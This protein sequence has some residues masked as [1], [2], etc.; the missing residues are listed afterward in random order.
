M[1]PVNKIKYNKHV[2]R[3]NHDLVAAMYAMY[4]T[5]KSCDA[6]AV[7]YRRSRQAIY[8]MFKT[9]G[10]KLRERK[11]LP[12]IMF[13]GLKFTINRGLYRMTTTRGKGALLHTYIYEKHH[14]P[15]PAGH[16]I[17]HENGDVLDNRIEN[18]KLYSIKE[19]SSKFSPH[20][21]QFTSPKGSKIWRK[22][23][24]GRPDRLAKGG[25]NYE[26]KL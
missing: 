23:K 1:Q 4:C 2:L 15:V 21:N 6:V 8:D 25:D 11:Y 22:G 12:Y 16:G 5:G 19:I 26:N 13:D 24:F 20:L 7:S 3:K 18:L 17:H 9:R 10:Y 14:G